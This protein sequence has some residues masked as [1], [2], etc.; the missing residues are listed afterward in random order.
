MKNKPNHI[1]K[2]TKCTNGKDGGR[3]HY[4]ACDYCDRTQVWRSV[5]CCPEHYDLYIKE[6][7]A[8]RGQ[9]VPIDILPDR[10]DKTKEEVRELMVAPIEEVTAKTKEDLKDYA[11]QLSE[12][13]LSSVIETINNEIDEEAEKATKSK[14]RRTKKV[15]NGED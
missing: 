5:A 1:C 4:F 15:T 6:V 9:S 8:A 2:Y 14:K 11:E 3:K 10:T 7:L 13:G 12:E